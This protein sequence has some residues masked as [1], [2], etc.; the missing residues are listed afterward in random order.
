MNLNRN[1]QKLFLILKSLRRW[2]ESKSM[3]CILLKSSC[4]SE[5]LGF[6]LFN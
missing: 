2:E 3:G 4:G 1:Y 6:D 5:D